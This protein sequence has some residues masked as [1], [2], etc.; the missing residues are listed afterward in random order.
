MLCYVVMSLNWG[1]L[2]SM[3]HEREGNSASNRFVCASLLS[4]K[5]RFISSRTKLTIFEE[6]FCCVYPVVI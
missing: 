4:S 5:D 2:S 3:S 1:L 6:N